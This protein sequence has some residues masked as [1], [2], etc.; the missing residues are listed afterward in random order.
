M[1]ISN[2]YVKLPKGIT[3]IYI[4]I[5]IYITPSTSGNPPDLSHEHHQGELSPT[6]DPWDDPPSTRNED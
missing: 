4:I 1:A 6:Y 2:S 3:H 5:Y